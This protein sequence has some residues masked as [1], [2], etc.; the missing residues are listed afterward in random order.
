MQVTD[1]KK[2]MGANRWG[3]A[4]SSTMKTPT[5]P[6]FTFGGMQINST[7]K[8]DYGVGQPR[9][10]VGTTVPA[11]A[12]RASLFRS[13]TSSFKDTRPITSKEYQNEMI[14]TIYDFLLEHDGENCLPEKVIRSPTKQDF[15][16]MFESIY[17]HLNPDFQLKNVAEEVP[18]IFRGLGYPTAIKP[19]TMQ[20]IGASHSWPTLLGA[21]TWLIE[22]VNYKYSWLNAGFKEY[23]QN[24]DAL[25]KEDFFDDKIRALRNWHEQQE[26]FDSQ[27]QAIQ[28]TLDQLSEDCAE[29]EADKGNVG[30]IREDI[31]RLDD[32]IKKAIDY[33]EE[34]E[35]DVDQLNV[36]LNAAKCGTLAVLKEAEEYRC[37]VAGLHSAIKA[38]EENQGL[39]DRDARALVAE[40]DDN[41]LAMRKLKAELEELCRQHWLE[42][43]KCK[44]AL[45]EQ[46]KRY[47]KLMSDVRNLYM[48]VLNESPSISEDTPKDA[49][50]LYSAV[51]NDVTALLAE[52]ESSFL[53]RKQDL[54]QHIRQNSSQAE[55]IKQ[56]DSV[57][58]RILRD[59]ERE[60]SRADRQRKHEREE[61]EKDVIAAEADVE[62]I[63][64][65]RE[66]L[67]NRRNEIGSLKRD[68]ESMKSENAQFSK[69]LAEKQS[70]IKDEVLSRFHLIVSDLD[71]MK[72]ARGWMERQLEA[73]ISQGSCLDEE[74]NEN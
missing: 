42:V 20:T 45:A 53:Q 63:E 48:I 37:R 25:K 5:R 47:Q 11:S 70:C 52:T 2:S 61:W 72:E 1:R 19:S 4:P 74:S 10:S 59:K 50:A 73:F 30:R 9:F 60:E 64:N 38:Q 36:E 13:I 67:E 34:T 55:E 32:D 44:D 43:P 21:L 54:E 40:I 66:V 31:I 17:Q 24:A 14:R 69:I 71:M 8:N 6:R 12:R 49:R 16:F 27:Q 51:L 46:Q 68:L 35:N 65:E 56:N 62:R 3:G 33:K 22:V 7:S 15:V 41:K 57:E 26:D 39:C 58:R 28:A 23:I 29:L 18:M